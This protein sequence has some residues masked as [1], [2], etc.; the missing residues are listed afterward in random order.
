MYLART[1][2]SV[3]AGVRTPEDGTALEQQG[4]GRIQSVLIDVTRDES[5]EAARREVQRRVGPAGLDGL[6]NNAG[7]G[8]S[9]PLEHITR[10]GL[11]A[12]FRVNV[13]GPHSPPKR[14]CHCFVRHAAASSTSGP[15]T[16][17]SR[18]H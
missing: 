15:R 4:N 14:F 6:V 17:V 7:V 12:Q 16:L 11:E 9:G 10:T 1:G 8:G 13:F 18:S 3:L 2:I 5:I